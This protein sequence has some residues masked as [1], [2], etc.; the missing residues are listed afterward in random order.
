[1]FKLKKKIKNFF[2]LINFEIDD[3]DLEQIHDEI[4]LILLL[5]EVFQVKYD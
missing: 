1:M 3:N 4:D 5:M 2:Q